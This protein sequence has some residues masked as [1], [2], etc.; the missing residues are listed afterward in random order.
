VPGDFI[1]QFRAVGAYI[2]LGSA[3]F[4]HGGAEVPVMAAPDG[5]FDETAGWIEFFRHL[6][7]LRSF[8]QFGVH[9]LDRQGERLGH[10]GSVSAL[11]PNCNLGV[12]GCCR[13]CCHG[14]R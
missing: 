12:K 7:E 3:A 13:L 4:G 5:A 2:F 1:G 6:T 14:R 8:R 10:G 9:G 11:P